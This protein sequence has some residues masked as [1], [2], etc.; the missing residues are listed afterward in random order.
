MSLWGVFG[1]CGTLGGCVF[2]C[3]RVSL[4]MYVSVCVTVG[5]PL[6]ILIPKVPR[7]YHKRCQ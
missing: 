7:T 5:C 1:V 3:P 2:L 4:F 6:R